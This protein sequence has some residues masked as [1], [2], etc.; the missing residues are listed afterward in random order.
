ML[1]VVFQKIF[2]NKNYKFKNTDTVI[3][4]SIIFLIFGVEYAEIW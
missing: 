1:N 2:H 3:I 4:Y